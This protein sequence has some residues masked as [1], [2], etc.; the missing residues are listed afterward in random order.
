MD[1]IAKTFGFRDSDLKSMPK[2]E[3]KDI[4]TGGENAAIDGEVKDVPV[5]DATKLKEEL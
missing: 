4:K 3:D 2:Y 5:K 1:K